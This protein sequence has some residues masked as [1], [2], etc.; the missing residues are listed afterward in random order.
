MDE[1]EILW[2]ERLA[3]HAA[4]QGMLVV[5]PLDG[6]TIET[7]DG[8]LGQLSED[9]HHPSCGHEIVG[10]GGLDEGQVGRAVDDRQ[11]LEDGE[12]GGVE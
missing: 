12:F 10:D 7:H 8:P 9:A 5:A 6:A 1:A 11:P 4:Q 3:P 2:S